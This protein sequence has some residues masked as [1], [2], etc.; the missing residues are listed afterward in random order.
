[1]EKT[2]PETKWKDQGSAADRLWLALNTGPGRAP[3]VAASF[4]MEKIKEISE[5]LERSCENW[6]DFVLI[7]DITTNK[8]LQDFLFI[9]FQVYEWIKLSRLF[10]FKYFKANNLFF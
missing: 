9:N 8:R 5:E 6:Q 10:F 3:T 7:V 2:V 1:M 4:Q